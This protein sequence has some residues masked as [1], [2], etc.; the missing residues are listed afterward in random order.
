MV[1]RIMLRLKVCM[2]VSMLQGSI[3]INTYLNLRMKSPRDLDSIF[4]LLK[5]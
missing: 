4:R 5:L 1:H 2:I 3:W